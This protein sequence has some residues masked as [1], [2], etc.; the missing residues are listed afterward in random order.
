MAP[1]PLATPAEVA[2]YL[3]TSTGQLAQM[4]YRGGGPVYVR[5]AGNRI[6]YRWEDVEA[7][8]ES[9]RYAQT[10]T[11]PIAASR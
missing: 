3:S 5:T 4:R 6:R 7:W 1:R 2:E 9:R 8:V 10:G 11:A